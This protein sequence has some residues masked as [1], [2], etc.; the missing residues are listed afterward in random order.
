[1]T[2]AMLARLPGS[3]PA[4]SV[5]LAH[6]GHPRPHQWGRALGVGERTAWRWLAD[7]AA[8]RPAALA[9][10]FASDLGYSVIASDA[11]WQLATAR[12]LAASLE[13]ERRELL[14]QLERVQQLAATGAANLPIMAPGAV[15]LP[16][17]R[18]ARA[19]A[20]PLRANPGP[21]AR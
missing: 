14:A 15:S 1:M 20:V 16:S 11:P 7:D 5:I 10:W 4:L 9:L 13:A 21:H 3:L 6:L 8:P 12:A 19:V 17:A 2:A 18:P